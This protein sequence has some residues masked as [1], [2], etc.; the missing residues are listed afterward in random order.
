M[1]LRD[2]KHSLRWF[3]CLLLAGAAIFALAF[4]GPSQPAASTAGP[5][6]PTASA[7]GPPQPAA[8]AARSPQAALPAS[9]ANNIVYIYY[10]NNAQHT[11]EVGECY[12]SCCTTWTCTG[13]VTNYYT[14][15][16]F[17]CNDN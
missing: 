15:R 11:T 4:A 7:A 13:Q 12:H 16:E 1:T 9:C 5:P 8:L 6:Q 2:T 17:S 10:F 14:L 3:F